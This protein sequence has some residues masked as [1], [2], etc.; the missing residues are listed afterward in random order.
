[1]DRGGGQSRGGGDAA[2]GAAV[3]AQAVDVVAGGAATG[4]RLAGIGPGRAG[5]SGGC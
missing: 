5:G 1:M 2:V 4:I 3:L